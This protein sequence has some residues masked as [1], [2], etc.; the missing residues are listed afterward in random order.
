MKVLTQWSDYSQKMRVWN[1]AVAAW[2]GLDP[3]KVFKLDVDDPDPEYGV[4]DHVTWSAMERL[5]PTRGEVEAFGMSGSGDD[6]PTFTGGVWLDGA[7]AAE[8]TAAIGPKPKGPWETPEAQAQL[9]RLRE[10]DAQR[11]TP[12]A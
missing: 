1:L 2:L 3:E 9:A 4:R 6:P 12:E 5:I 10:R 8:F 11:S 7:D